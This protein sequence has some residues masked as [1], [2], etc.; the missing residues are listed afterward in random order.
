M[1]IKSLNKMK[2]DLSPLGFNQGGDFELYYCTP[3]N[4]KILA[5]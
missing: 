3:E 2:I 4:A 5:I 1:D